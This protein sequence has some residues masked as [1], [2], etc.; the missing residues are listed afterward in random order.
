MKWH[1]RVVTQWH[2]SR[3]SS[4]PVCLQVHV[5]SPLFFTVFTRK[6][7]FWPPRLYTLRPRRRRR[8]RSRGGMRTHNSVQT[9]KGTGCTD[10]GGGRM[11]SARQQTYN[12]QSL[13]GKWTR[14]GV[15]RGV[16]HEREE[17]LHFSSAEHGLVD[18]NACPERMSA[19]WLIY[20]YHDR[21]TVQMTNVHLNLSFSSFDSRLPIHKS[22][23]ICNYGTASPNSVSM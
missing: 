13:S 20:H 12:S 4:Q 14:Q 1:A 6:N 16:E 21:C 9:W 5:L 19:S 11:F 17:Q 22:K 15:V 7:S 2:C 18:R 8:R 23:W 10:P 3:N